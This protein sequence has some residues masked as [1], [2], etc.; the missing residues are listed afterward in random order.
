MCMSDLFKFAFLIVLLAGGA[1]SGGDRSRRSGAGVGD[2]SA[3]VPALVALCSEMDYSDT[4]AL[5]DEGV[6]TEQMINIVKLLPLT[7]SVAAREALVRFFNGISR[8]ERS[9]AIADSLGDLYLNNP[10]SPVRDERLYI[11]FLDAML[12]VDSLPE[13]AR[14]R[15][16]GLLH[17]ARLNRPG[18][19]ANDFRFIDRHGKE[20]TLHAMTG[21]ELLLIFY[22]PDCAH[23]SD[24]LS[25]IAGDEQINSM[26][27]SGELTVLAVYA[28]GKRD[29]WDGTKNEMPRNWLVGYDLTGVLEN[30]LYDLPAM[31]T[32]YLLDAD[33]R[34]VLK[35]PEATALS[36]Y[37]RASY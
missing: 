12:S 20:G 29:V 32:L 33:H 30:D 28:E 1:C 19:V 27:A 21:R 18:S 11:R 31:P 16:E 14:I 13:G 35:D 3:E 7:D 17:T 10:S 8:D 15:A 37:L 34:V 24:I 4:A 6:M 23:C 9:V 2:D 26:V 36:G 22:D 25:Y 5:R